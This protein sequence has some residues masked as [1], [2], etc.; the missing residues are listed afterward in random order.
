AQPERPRGP[1]DLADEDGAQ[2]RR[3]RWTSTKNELDDTISPSAPTFLRRFLASFLRCRRVTTA[4]VVT[5]TANPVA[6][7]AAA[8]T[9]GTGGRASGA[10]STTPGSSATT[11][12]P[13]TT[14]AST[15]ASSSTTSGQP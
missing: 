10:A 2:S 12:R 6:A 3:N 8:W 1:H 9:A 15:S 5:P 7:S 4:A 14:S 11:G 13:S